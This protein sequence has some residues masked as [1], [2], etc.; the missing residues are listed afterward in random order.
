MEAYSSLVGAKYALHNHVDRILKAAAAG[1]EAAN[2][3]EGVTF[4]SAEAFVAWFASAP[5]RP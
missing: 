3:A 2:E 5:R 4:A 1:R